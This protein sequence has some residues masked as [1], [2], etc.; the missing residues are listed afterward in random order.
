MIL[1]F[2]KSIGTTVPRLLQ[3]KD[4]H[5][6]VSIEYH[7][8]HFGTDDQDDTWLPV[9]GNYGWTIVGHDIYLKHDSEISALKQYGI[10]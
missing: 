9:V 6:P 8:Q 10:G 4:L 5:F 2:D 1:F 7:E 3:W